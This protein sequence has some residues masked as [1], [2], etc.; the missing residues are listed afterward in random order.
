L[1]IFGDEMLKRIFGSEKEALQ[2]TGRDCIMRKYI[3]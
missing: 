3:I 2:E 1:R